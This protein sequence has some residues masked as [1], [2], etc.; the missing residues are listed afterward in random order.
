MPTKKENTKPKK[1]EAKAAD[2]ATAKKSKE[3]K[4]ASKGK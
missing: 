1:R 4:S 3:S 2:K